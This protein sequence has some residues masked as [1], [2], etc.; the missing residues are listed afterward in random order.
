[1]RATLLG[2]T[3]S[4]ILLVGPVLAQQ[5][6]PL[7]DTD[8]NRILTAYEAPSGPVDPFSVP[9]P[10]PLN[11]RVIRFA[12][13]I[14]MEGAA[15]GHPFWSW[16]YDA[17]SGR[18]S[19]RILPSDFNLMNTFQE[20]TE[21]VVRPG[22]PMA[23]FLTFREERREG[24]AVMRNSYGASTTVEVYRSTEFGFASVSTG[25]TPVFPG[26]ADRVTFLTH[27]VRLAAEQARDLA[28][29]L[30]LVV[31]GEVIDFRA[32]RSIVCG[33]SYSEPTIRRPKEVLGRVCVLSSRISRVAIVDARTGDVLREWR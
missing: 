15:D 2:L 22:S 10:S 1:M 26:L 11:G 3:A 23:G 28:A 12:R 21:F 32:G 27:E 7:S 6:E 8:I 14:K 5:A 19:I 25:Y 9:G 17:V 20:G 18:L 16:S 30:Q 33:T 24:S 31:D 29:N 4:S 13:E